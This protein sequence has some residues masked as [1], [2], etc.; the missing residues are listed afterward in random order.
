MGSMYL[1]LK[2]MAS[3]VLCLSSPMAE[4]ISKNLPHFK[5]NIVR[6]HELIS[7]IGSPGLNCVP[8]WARYC[9]QREINQLPWLLILF[10][11]KWDAHPLSRILYVAEDQKKDVFKTFI[12]PRW[13]IVPWNGVPWQNSSRYGILKDFRNFEVSKKTIEGWP[14]T[15]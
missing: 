14:L 9:F 3:L 2:V 13:I 15:L 7:I 5:G 4:A 1:I 11:L 8:M 12:I 10:H 6:S